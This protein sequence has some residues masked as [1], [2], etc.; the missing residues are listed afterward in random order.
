MNDVVFCF[1]F[2]YFIALI[3]FTLRI[4]KV[5]LNRIGL[6]VI[7]LYTLFVFSYLGAFPLY[8][9]WFPYRVSCGISEPE[10]VIRLLLYSMTAITTVVGTYLLLTYSSKNNLSFVDKEIGSHFLKKKNSFGSLLILGLIVL[11]FMM[12]LQKIEKIALFEVFK[13]GFKAGEKARSLMGNN[14][15]GKY[16]RYKVFIVDILNFVSFS[17]FAKYLI[18]KDFLSKCLFYFT[19]SF[20]IFTALFTTQKAPILFLLIGYF[21]V[22]VM[23]AKKGKIPLKESFIA[24]AMLMGIGSLTY[25]FFMNTRM[26]NA[27]INVLNR[28]LTGQLASAYFY[29]EYFPEVSPFLNGLSMPNFGGVFP[30]ESFELTKELMNWKFPKLRETGMVGTMPAPFWGEGYANFGIFGIFMFSVISGFLIY[31]AEFFFSRIEK[32]PVSIG[33]YIW[34]ILH[35][36]DLALGGL[37][38]FIFDFYLGSVLIAYFIITMIDNLNLSFPSKNR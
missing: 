5:N 6:F 12:Y 11:V 23:V 34:M 15:G 37:F 30:H 22:Y 31:I 9:E 16:H 27:L 25:V 28:T 33:L 36:K 18:S 13:H 17:Y 21:F 20:S 1:V 35:Y 3:F 4:L 26:E 32:N 14:F 38:N 19:F 8:F 2:F 7:T 10:K 29:T 24:L